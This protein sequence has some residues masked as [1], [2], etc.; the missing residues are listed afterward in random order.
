MKNNPESCHCSKCGK[1]SPVGYFEDRM[2]WLRR[3]YKKYHPRAWK[4]SVAKGVANRT[5]ENPR[6]LQG[7]TEIE[8]WFERDRAHV[9]LRW[10]DGETIIEWWDKDVAQAVDDGFLDPRDWHG[11]AIEYAQHRGLL[12]NPGPM[13]VFELQRRIGR[14][15]R[16]LQERVL[17][18]LLPEDK[19]KRGL[20]DDMLPFSRGLR[21]NPLDMNLGR[22]WIY[23]KELRELIPDG[24]YGVVEADD[25]GNIDM[26]YGDYSS[27]DQA[28]NALNLFVRED[29]RR[30]KNGITMV[31][32]T[33]NRI[34]FMSHLIDPFNRGLRQNPKNSPPYL[35]S[36]LLESRKMG[37]IGKT[38]EQRA[39]NAQAAA[40]VDSMD[41]SE[42]N[43]AYR[44]YR[45]L[46]QKVEGD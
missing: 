23:E 26:F 34:Q 16:A 13:S 4:R 36:I 38:R 27:Y 14:G 43:N 3:H 12:S 24:W 33:G 7:Q 6:S 18:T 42:R 37:L 5:M 22:H 2:A 19:A 8:T 30:E 35:A 45:K 40:L 41:E 1:R 31:K 9:E 15:Q 25:N 17:D 20:V 10:K 39:L 46:L 29:E 44:I 28:Q 32:R 21:Q 11:S